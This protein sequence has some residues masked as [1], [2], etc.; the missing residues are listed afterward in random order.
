MRKEDFVPVLSK[1]FKNNSGGGI[2]ALNIRHPNVFLLPA[3][4][5]LPREA[6]GTKGEF[7]NIPRNPRE[8][9]TDPEILEKITSK[10]F[11]LFMDDMVANMVWPF[12]GRRGWIEVYSGYSPAYMYAHM[13]KHW[14]N[15]LHTLAEGELDLALLIAENEDI[16]WC[17]EKE[18]QEIWK[19]C[20]DLSDK[21]FPYMKKVLEIERQFPCFED[22]DLQNKKLHQAR[23]YIDFLRKWTHS[24]SKY[25]TVPLIKVRSAGV[26]VISAIDFKIDYQAFL[27]KLSA[28]ERKLIALRL[29]GKTTT[30]I[31]ALL[32]LKTHSAVVK[33]LQKI[34]EKYRWWFGDTD[35]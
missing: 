5:T 21:H 35:K 6:V 34:Q 22:F 33:R 10:R 16:E 14:V 4:Y 26:D 20:A 17:T 2:V 25:Q 28:D 24:Q 23:S 7:S 15:I 32:G 1:Y 27:K 3:Y 8:V 11:L 19:D 31:A 9:L 29:K 30:E 18:S 13:L 12:I